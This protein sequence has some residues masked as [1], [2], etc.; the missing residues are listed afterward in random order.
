MART[1]HQAVQPAAR[2]VLESVDLDRSGLCTAPATLASTFLTTSASPTFSTGSLPSFTF[3]MT[4]GSTTRTASG[5]SPGVRSV[6]FLSFWLNSFQ[7]RFDGNRLFATHYRDQK[8]S[9]SNYLDL[10][11]RYLPN[12]VSVC[13]DCCLCHA[14]S[15]A[16]PG[17]YWNLAGRDWMVVQGRPAKSVS[18]RSLCIQ[19][20]KGT[21]EYR[22]GAVLQG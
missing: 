20:V 15:G 3:Q 13:L 12:P 7:G 1:V 9:P 4:E 5:S 11:L 10:L 18:C 8:A 22:A 19:M 14:C 17:R 2:S 6:S 21:H 16:I